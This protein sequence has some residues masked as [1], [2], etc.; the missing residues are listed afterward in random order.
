VIRFFNFIFIFGLTCEGKKLG[1]DKT[2]NN[3]SE[4]GEVI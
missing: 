2:L 1:F 3:K 4:A